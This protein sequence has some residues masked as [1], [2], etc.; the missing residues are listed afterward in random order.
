ME[1]SRSED[2]VLVQYGKKADNDVDDDIY[3]DPDT[4]IEYGDTAQ[5]DK[6]VGDK[7]EDNPYD[8]E[9]DS[10][11]E[12]LLFLFLG[13]IL[14]MFLLLLIMT[15]CVTLVIKISGRRNLILETII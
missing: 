9:T 12:S 10:N 1:P 3:P 2:P 8:M 7:M 15:V 4:V 11:P 14:L 5:L 13:G 6:S